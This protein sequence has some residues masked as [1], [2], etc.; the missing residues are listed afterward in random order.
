MQCPPT[1]DAAVRR[2]DRTNGLTPID[3]DGR[4]SAAR[5]AYRSGDLDDAARIAAEILAANPGNLDAIELKALVEIERG[6]YAEAEASLRFAIAVAPERR[7]AYADLT[8]L[9]LKL[10]RS[11]EAEAVARGAAA[12]DPG[13]ADAH[14]MLGSILAD[15][16]MY[17]PAAAHLRRAIALAGRHP[18]LLV[19]LGRALMLQGSPDQAR[20]LLEEAAAADPSML[21]P[22]VSLAEL[23]ER[24]G[25]FDEALRLLDGA[26][27]LA[28]ATGTDLKLQRSVLLERMGRIEAA[29][30]LLDDERELSGAALLHRGRLRDRLDRHADAWSDWTAGKALL[31]QSNARHYPSDEVQKQADA[32]AR[33]FT[34]EQ[35]AAF[36]G[37]AKRDD[38]PQPL[39]I[40]GFPRSGTTLTEQILAS[41]SRIRAGGELPFMADL[42]DHAV[43]LAV[44]ESAFPDGLARLATVQPDWAEQL[45]DFYLERAE[46]FGLTAPGAD[47][48]TDKMPLNE[49]WL[50]LLRI[51]FP[52]SPVILVRRHPLDVLTSVMAHDMTHGFHCG[53]RLRDAARHLAT[54]DRLVAGYRASGIE[55]TYEL[56]YETLVADQRGETQRLMAAIGLPLEEAQLRPDQRTAVSATPSYARVGEPLNDR[57]IG[58]WQHHASELEAIRPL[59]SEVIRQFES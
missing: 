28:A 24:S 26:E 3:P 19:A 27:P 36:P 23:E 21:E 20:T 35:F 50:P 34:S 47:F 32:L 15:R 8:R 41:H 45:R 17:V 37:A 11:A 56:R 52:Q 7:W 13:N 55:V 43:S 14:A 29:V 42:K 30:R 48:F 39:F 1:G 4:V 22:A 44:G 54:V 38:V 59:V 49:M 12:A 40:V 2:F 57:S 46:T 18:Q 10:G 25:R 53:Y 31:A 5:N 33:F 58:R 6:H 9:L 51:A 16:Q